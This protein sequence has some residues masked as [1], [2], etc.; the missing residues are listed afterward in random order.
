MFEKK[1][2]MLQEV[3]KC[4]S[5]QERGSSKL[6]SNTSFRGEIV[7]KQLRVKKSRTGRATS[8]SL[9]KVY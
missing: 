5:V 3:G 7:R 4:Y 1:N 2:K 6:A 8:I 9:Y